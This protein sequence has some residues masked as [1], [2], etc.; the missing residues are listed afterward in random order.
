M[1]VTL[2]L[3]ASAAVG[4][5]VKMKLHKMPQTHHS[6]YDI[7]AMAKRLKNQYVTNYF[8]SQEARARE[9]LLAQMQG[10]SEFMSEFNAVSSD[11]SVP[12]TNFLNAQYFAEIELGTPAQKFN[13][14]LDTG[15]SNLWVPSTKCSS[16]ACL[17][18]SKY[19]ASQSSTYKKNGT[20]F[21]IRYGSG[22]LSGFVSQ[23]TLRIGDLIVKK[24][25][26][27]E[28]TQEPGL[29]F[30]FG[31]FDGILGLAYDTISVDRIVPPIYNMIDQGLLD[32]PLFSFY[33][34][35]TNA[36]EEGGE[37]TIG[38]IDESHIK[39][40]AKLIKLPVRRK[41][42]WEVALDGMT[43]GN[44]TVELP[45][46]GAA[47]D[48]GTSLIALPTALAEILNAQMGAK[49]GFN[50]QYTIDCDKREDLPDLTFTLSGYNFTITA[51]DYVLEVQGSCI[52][53]F[54]GIDFPPQI[55]SMAILGDAFL[56]RF[57]SV[58]NLKDNTVG[59]ALSN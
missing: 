36:G 42:Y 3:L 44:E 15:S 55:G 45:E 25:D 24:Q 53:A 31:R 1:K 29:A 2:L 57:Y 47:I 50:G 58:Y 54:M 14:I 59:L 6:A 27:A 49:K 33:L 20:K 7:P 32:E 56:R 16:I 51:Y 12:L 10:D 52:S 26:F 22:E 9:E 34:G 18:H 43:F 41:A 35:D 21:E 28:A 46:H 40:K 30:A 19:D 8:K 38:G 5:M 13:V 37:F 23:D 39:S 48:T 17:L 4:E 11:H